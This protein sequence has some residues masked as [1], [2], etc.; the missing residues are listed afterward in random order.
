MIVVDAAAFVD[1]LTGVS[2]SEQLRDRLAVEEL[3]A[4]ALVDYQFVSAVRGMTL[5]GHL[6]VTRAND[7]LS[8]FE[9]LAV[10][11]W[12]AGDALRRRAYSLR[13][14]LSA[15]DAAYVALAEALGCDLV[16]RDASLARAGGHDV[17]IIVG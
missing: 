12:E 4:P 6:T 2:G 8:D 7:A 13:D 10:Q 16:T 14:N 5:R 9:A 17:S 11:R 15:Y 1:A 3:H